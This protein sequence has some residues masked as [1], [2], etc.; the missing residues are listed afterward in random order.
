LINFI[1]FVNVEKDLGFRNWELGF[2]S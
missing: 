1:F 2:G